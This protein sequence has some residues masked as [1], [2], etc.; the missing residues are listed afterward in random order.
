MDAGLNQDLPQ[1]HQLPHAIPA[2]VPD[3]ARYFIT[4]NCR[5]RGR[6]QLCRQPVAP[7]LLGRF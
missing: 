1:R 6:N 2:W 3:G 7:A 4:I 5:E